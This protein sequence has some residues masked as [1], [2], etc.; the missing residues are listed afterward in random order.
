MD[1]GLVLK[2]TSNQRYIVSQTR[3]AFRVPDT[4]CPRLLSAVVQYSEGHD[5]GAPAGRSP[6][7]RSGRIVFASS[8]KGKQSLQV[9]LYSSSTRIT[10]SY[11]AYSP[12]LHRDY[13]IGNVDGVYD[14]EPQGSCVAPQSDKAE[15]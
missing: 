7:R 8:L 13:W 9:P 14:E 4:S 3:P 2:V 15:K 12:P 11:E 6:Y 5:D 1:V 10:R